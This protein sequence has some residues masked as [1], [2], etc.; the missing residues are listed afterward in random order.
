MQI[1]KIRPGPP[2][3]RQKALRHPEAVSAPL[4]V[5]LLLPKAYEGRVPLPA[6]VRARLFALTRLRHRFPPQTPPARIRTTAN[7]RTKRRPTRHTFPHWDRSMSHDLRIYHRLWADGT[8]DSA[9]L[10]TRPLVLSIRLTVL[11]HAMPPRCQSCRKTRWRRFR[12]D[13]HSFRPRWW[14]HLVRFRKT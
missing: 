4:V 7:Q 13:G 1:F 8:K 6:L 3:H 10:P 14:V 11:H 2:Q 9:V 5:A 12:K